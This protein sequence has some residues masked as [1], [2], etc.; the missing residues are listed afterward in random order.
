MLRRIFGPTRDE[1][2]REWKKLHNEKLHGLY[3]SQNIIQVV[4]SRRISKAG[5][6]AHMR[7]REVHT[8]VCWGDLRGRRPL[9]KL[10]RRRE[11][12][13]KVNLREV[14]WGKRTVSI[15]LR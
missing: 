2:K 11:G 1:V 15:W 6:M 8:G 3:S 13:I 9:G 12:N 14:A 10:T 7:R 4:K 5:Y